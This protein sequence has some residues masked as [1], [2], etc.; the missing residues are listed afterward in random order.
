[1]GRKHI[2]HGKEAW[3]QTELLLFLFFSYFF[4]LA[5]YPA[6]SPMVGFELMTRTSW[7][8]DP[9]MKASAEIKGQMLNWLSHPI[10]TNGVV[11]GG[12]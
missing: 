6:W 11:D 1:M 4:K 8:E 10:I 7:D 2:Y 9:E 5:P 3:N 12:D